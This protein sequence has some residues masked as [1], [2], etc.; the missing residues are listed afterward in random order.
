MKKT[1]HVDFRNLRKKQKILMIMKLPLILTIVLFVG[2]VQAGLSQ[3]G[4][5]TLKLSDVSVEN[6]FQEIEKSSNYRF[7]YQIDDVANLD[8]VNLNLIDADIQ[9]ILS[10]CF[11]GSE[12][13]YV[14]ENDY[15]IIHPAEKVAHFEEISIDIKGKITDS[16]GAPLPGATIMEDGTFNGITTDAE[17]NY[18][19]TVAGST[20]VIKVS[21]IGFRTQTI[22]VGDKTEI[23]VV[24]EED[25]Q[26]LNEVVVTGYQTLSKERT[27]G[28]FVKVNKEQ[29]EE[30]MAGDNILDRIEATSTGVNIEKDKDG[31]HIV[32]IRGISTMKANSTPLYVVDGFA[33]EGDIS[34]INP[35]DV[36]SVTIL[37]DASAASIWGVKAAN[38][39]IVITTKR[40]KLN[41]RLNVEYNSRVTISE[42]IPWDKMNWMTPSEHI[43]VLM[44]FD[45]HGYN[46][47]L[48]NDVMRGAELST[49]E[50]AL[51]HR[52][53]YFPNGNT[54]TEAQFQDW[55]E[56]ARNTNNIDQ[57]NDLMFRR[58]IRST[59]NLSISGGSEKNGFFGSV[60]YNDNLGVSIGNADNKINFNIQDTY[61]FN[62]KVDFTAGLNLTYRRS[63]SNGL[64]PRG[65]YQPEWDLLVDEYG[66]AIQ[67]YNYSYGGGGRYVV[68]EREA[69]TGIRHSGSEL[70][71]VRA[72][73]NTTKELDYRA[74]FGLN[75]RPIKGLTISSKFQFELG[76]SRNDD[77]T[78]MDDG[79]WRTKVANYYVDGEFQVP[80]GDRYYSTKNEKNAW[81]FR[82]TANYD[83]TIGDHKFTVFVGSEIRKF[84]ADYLYNLK[85][86]YDQQLTTATPINSNDFLGGAIYNW[87]G[88]AYRES[89]GYWN[90]S[91]TDNREFSFFSNFGYT[92]KDKYVLNASYRV[93][94]KNLFGSD[95]DYR[96]KPLWSVGLGWNAHKEDFMQNVEWVNRLKLRVTYGLSG[97]ASNLYSPY[98]QAINVQSAA[99]GYLFNHLLLYSAANPQLRWE[100]TKTFNVTVDFAL[101]NNK[102]NGTIEYYDRQSTDLIGLRSLDPTNGFA[103]ADVN[104]ASMENKG[105]EI[106]LNTTIFRNADWKWD[107]AINFSY[108]KNNVTSVD[109]NTLGPQWYAWGDY[110]IAAGLPLKNIWSFNYGGLDEAG[111]IQLNY[112]DEN[113]VMQKKPWYEGVSEE[114]ELIYHGPG[115]SPITGGG[116]T[117][118]TYK[119]FDLTV[120]FLYKIGGYFHYS[121]DL[122]DFGQR[123]SDSEFVDRWQKPGDELTTRIPK[124]PYVG[125]NPFN[126][127]PENYW[128]FYDAN[129][130]YTFSQ[131][132]IYSKSFFKVR[133]IIFT[134]NVPKDLA[135]K[136][137]LQGLRVSCQ[138]QNPFLWVANEKGMDVTSHYGG[139]PRPWV[140][141]K[142]ITF[143]VKA[144]F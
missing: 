134:Y 103:T 115:I 26:A 107:A 2:N 127:Q 32:Q 117:K 3:S 58:S 48:L 37:K 131:D 27:T 80:V 30:R 50:E 91:N 140:N 49:W 82:N 112:E 135:Q 13:N 15:I 74:T 99:G 93:D 16:D 110:H 45:D 120:N 133:D 10:E 33:I 75:L 67:Y 28:S 62:D 142:T 95:P 51:A 35:D 41:Q 78:T 137:Y 23:N 94:Q 18:T 4:K 8:K 59:Y 105:I 34:T 79:S 114:E 126:G 53:G 14:M 42:N 88:D 38:G 81:N 44:E 39:V 43:D 136:L 102:I 11:E 70:E 138:I 65:I 69:I 116:S 84:S 109:V 25:S 128:D 52:R 12:L 55:V 123:R 63:Q 66:Q 60:S 118:I 64:D 124:I 56:T 90:T 119:N 9:T 17:G 19:L 143:G 125:T 85:L 98:A 24:L 96:Y 130:Y 132:N 108:N 113:G 7:V 61:K 21:F 31:N 5:F 22:E 36:E 101:F 72:S 100:E 86:G 121:S 20:S 141:M 129:D 83:K 54:W 92:F 97:N 47:N 68:Q 40:G 77:F 6:V 71:D 46:K 122:S 87:K 76:N 29:L 111:V 106:A 139:D 1:L 104:Y 144:T 73:D 89:A 57:Y